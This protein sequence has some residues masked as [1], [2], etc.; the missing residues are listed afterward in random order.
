MRRLSKELAVATIAC[1]SMAVGCTVDVGPAPTACDPEG[2]CR[3]GYICE[4]SSNTC[5]DAI[6]SVTVA[7]AG[8]GSGTVVSTPAGID[9]GMMCTTDVDYGTMLSFEAT[10]DA[11]SMFAGWGGDCTGMGTCEV[12][13]DHAVSVTATFER[14]VFDLTVTKS[15][16]GRGTVSSMPAGIDC[17]SSC[18]AGFEIGTEVTLAAEAEPG[19]TFEG[20]TGDCT[21][22]G[23]CMVSMDA[24]KDVEAVFSPGGV[25]WALEFGDADFD[26]GTSLAIDAE[27]NVVAA[28][29]FHGDADFGGTT[30]SSAG[31]EDIFVAKYAGTDGSLMW[32]KRFGGIDADQ[33]QALTVDSA[34]DVFVSGFYQQ[35]ADFGDGPTTSAGGFDVFLVKLSGADGSPIWSRTFGDSGTDGCFDIAVDSADNPILTGN[36]QSTVDFGSGTPITAMGLFDGFAV[37]YRGSDGGYLWNTRVGGPSGTDFAEGIAVSSDDHAFIIGSFGTSITF[38]PSMLTSI[39]N[40]D[41]FLAELDA[42][43]GSFVRGFDYGGTGFD[44]GTAIDIDRSD[45]SLL[46]TCA[47]E[48]SAVFGGDPLVSAGFSDLAVAKYSSGGTHQWSMAFGGTGRDYPYGIVSPRAGAVAAIGSFV[49]TVDLGRDVVS[50]GMDD[51]LVLS[52][53]SDGSVAWSRAFGGTGIDLG[54]NIAADSTGA[55]Y[56]TGSFESS[57][58]LGE[59]MLTSNGMGD[60]FLIKLGN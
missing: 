59:A 1:V 35:T 56:V 16:G 44:Y 51:V 2:R 36:F 46:T 13:A 7:L 20:W 48:G 45:G 39:G 34:G 22:L 47:F 11:M 30:L 60:V 14:L 12:V 19:F 43:D 37:K 57:V 28:G 29:Y 21:G 24:A 33:T 40:T 50:Q 52:L 58:D 9:C 23:S 3:D 31:A 42:A 4:P 5:V 6:Q 8:A 18:S 27:D 54:L 49:G 25:V 38:G 55:I 26:S 53:A 10:P 41:A 32:A 15:G 17:G